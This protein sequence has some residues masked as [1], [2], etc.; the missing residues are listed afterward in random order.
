MGER[1]VDHKE[2]FLVCIDYSG[3]IF[4]YS[5]LIWE[6]KFK[7]IHVFRIEQKGIPFHHDFGYLFPL[8]F[9]SPKKRESKKKRMNSKNREIKREWIVKIEIKSHS[10]LLDLLSATMS[11]I[12][13]CSSP[14]ERWRNT[15]PSDY[16]SYSYVKRCFSL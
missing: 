4:S 7:R 14:Y 1:Q 13:K 11:P 9:F 16:E 5:I 6:F 10:F 15:V 12:W 8:F 2:K 3:A